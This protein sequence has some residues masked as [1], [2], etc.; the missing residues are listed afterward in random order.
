M[1]LTLLLQLGV[2]AA[3]MQQLLVLTLFYDAPVLHN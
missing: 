1:A 3:L 2:G